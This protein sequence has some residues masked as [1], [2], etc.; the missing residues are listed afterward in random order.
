MASEVLDTGR[1]LGQRDHVR[2]DEHRTPCT[3]IQRKLVDPIRSIGFV[4]KPG[5]GS[6]S[7]VMFAEERSGGGGESGRGTELV[8]R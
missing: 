4:G 2:R 1:D 6:I 8:G 5:K 7:T 3:A